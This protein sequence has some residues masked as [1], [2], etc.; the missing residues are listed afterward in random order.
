MPHIS[1]LLGAGFSVPDGYKT[2]NQIN[3][4]L[5][6]ISSNEIEIDS[7]GTA[8]FLEGA[9]DINAISSFLEREFVSSFLEFYKNQVLN[10]REFDY[11]QFY[12]FY[13]GLERGEIK[14]PSFRKFSKNF[15]NQFNISSRSN[16]DLLNKF[17]NTFNQLLGQQ[18]WKP[19]GNTFYANYPKYDRILSFLKKIGK[20]NIIHIHTL[21]HDLLMEK[22]SNTA[23]LNTE[24]N[25][26]F[27]EMGSSYYGQLNNGYKVRLKYYTDYFE[28][29]FRLYKLH[30]SIDQIKFCSNDNTITA[31]KTLPSI[32]MTEFY[33]EYRDTDG[34]L[35]YENCWINY[36]TDFLSGT[37]EKINMYG[38]EYYYKNIFEHFQNNLKNSEKLFI[39]GYSFRD[40]GIN[41]MINK[42][43]CTNIERKAI[44]IDPVM[45]DI[46]TCLK[47]VT[48]IPFEKSI[49]EVTNEEL[50]EFI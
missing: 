44:I 39:I 34:K 50:I 25:D 36:F 28:S 17:N 47:N 38:T 45:P 22:F 24:L 8:F 20:E 32:R 12:D 43:F 35:K 6:T 2:S 23:Y 15:K 40:S 29:N 18:L 49:S 9:E 33:R 42:Y 48:I 4:R 3:N 7:D 19:I 26:G 11:E 14:S 46:G 30:G 5:K 41:N 16:N 1:F 27:E 37:T 13:K 10:E 21:N 31:I